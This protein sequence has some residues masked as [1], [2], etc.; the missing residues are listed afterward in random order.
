MIHDIRETGAMSP[1]EEAES[2]ASQPV[3]APVT[4]LAHRRAEVTRDAIRD[5]VTT[6]M[7]EGHPAAISIPAV[8]ERA[9]VS[10]RTVY[11]YFPN[12]QALLDDVAHANFVRVEK[13][14]DQGDALFDDPSRWLPFIWEC[15]AEDVS[16]VRAQHR[17]P[18][19]H[20]LRDRRLARS[21]HG[22]SALVADMAPGLGEPEVAILA[23]AIVATTSSAMFLEL[24]D[25]MGWTSRQSAEL[26]LWIVDAI[27][28]RIVGDDLGELTN[29][30][31]AD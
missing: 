4:D 3:S 31:S 1:A 29:L 7:A 8:A 17:S 18:A 14:A 19:G 2:S 28:K 16:A 20:D 5:A 9:G 30:L 15:F 11:R 26:A 23:D 27:R 22:V 13:L 24:H 6:L 10:V 21:R 25:R 12:K